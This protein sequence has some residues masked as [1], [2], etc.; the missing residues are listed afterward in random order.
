[1]NAAAE[2]T[3]TTP[4][5]SVVI[6]SIVGSPFIDDCLASVFAQ[7][8][9]PPFEVI[10]VDCRGPDNVA[11]LSKRFPEA[12]FIHLAKRET[13]PRL[14]SIGFEQSRGAIIAVIEEHCLAADNWLAT[15]SAAFSPDYVAVGGPVGFRDDGRLRDWITY[16][17]E[18][19]SYLPPWPDG[20]TFNVGSANA[21][22][23]RQTL[24]SNLALLTR[25]YW[26]ATLHPKLLGERAKFHSVPDMIV[27]H[28]G[29]FGY[30]Y[31][32]RQRYL[33]SR[34]FAGA[35]RP[36]LSAVKRAVYLLAAPVIPLLLLA[37]IGSRVFAKKCHPDKFLL[38]LPLLIPALA[39]YVV[40][41]WVG[42]AFGPGQALL[43]VE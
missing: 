27:Y 35:R 9:A 26:E 31:Y 11:R 2:R 28:R 39:S 21:A 25:G 17:I 1:V 4:A 22:Y 18:Y 3:T 8:N 7:K 42:Y 40:G 41:E 10:V 34:A 30:L 15:L 19:N 5:V 43:E 6:A 14:R 38:S 24:Q 32:L 36:S 23:R 12:R 29:P 13:V 37:R 16:F 33:F 20:E